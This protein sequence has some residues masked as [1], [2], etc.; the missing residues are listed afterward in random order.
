MTE[1]LAPVDEY[2]GLPLP[3]APLAV[4]LSFIRN[5]KR[6]LESSRS[7][8]HHHFYPN[9]SLES[10]GQRVLRHSRLQYGVRLLHDKYHRF[11]DRADLSGSDASCFEL[12]I[13]ATAG[14]IPELAVDVRGKN[15]RIVRLSE[16]Q[17]EEMQSQ[18]I[19]PEQRYSETTGRD[20][21]K[22]K[23]G[24]FFM[25]YALNQNFDHVKQYLLEEF[26]ET[27]DKK[28][29]LWLGSTIVDLAFWKASEQ[30]EGVY[31]SA[32]KAG[33]IPASQPKNSVGFL[34]S[35]VNGYQPDYFEAMESR[36]VA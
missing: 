21:N 14:Y 5:Q 6:Y 27:D 1:R 10:D 11:Y 18:T 8:E 36:I 28:R 4:D 20:M 34:R 33:L 9:A 16:Q 25:N 32:Y 22:I 26:I 15:P 3:I 35:V 13:L 7:D 19:Y 24:W 30:I 12:G 31:K 17:R 2:S 29:R 23:R